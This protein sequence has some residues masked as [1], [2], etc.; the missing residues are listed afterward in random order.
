MSDRSQFIQ[1]VQ[2]ETLPELIGELWRL[3]ELDAYQRGMVRQLLEHCAARDWVKA[4]D[5]F[6]GYF[7]ANLLG[8][9]M[10]Q[11]DIA[12]KFDRILSLL[13]EKVASHSGGAAA[14]SSPAKKAKKSLRGTKACPDCGAR[15]GT[16]KKKCDKCDYQFPVKSKV[17]NNDEGSSGTTS[18]EPERVKKR[19]SGAAASS[20][21]AKKAKKSLK[22][23][24]ACPV[25]GARYGTRKKKCDK[26]G[27]QFPVKSKANKKD[28]GSSEAVAV[29]SSEPEETGPF[30]LNGF[31]PLYNTER[32]AAVAGDGTTHSHD[33][34]GVT[35]YM[36][37]GV[38]YYHG[39]HTSTAEEPNKEE[40]AVS[41]TLTRKTNGTPYEVPNLTEGTEQP[42][43]SGAAAL[44]IG[45]E[46]RVTTAPTVIS[47]NNAEA[48]EGEANEDGFDNPPGL[49]TS[50]VVEIR[51]KPIWRKKLFKEDGQDFVRGKEGDDKKAVQ[52]IHDILTKKKVKKYFV[53]FPANS[54]KKWQNQHI[55]AEWKQTHDTKPPKKLDESDELVVHWR[56]K[57]PPEIEPLPIFLPEDDGQFLVEDMSAAMISVYLEDADDSGN[58]KFKFKSDILLKYVEWRQLPDLPV[59]APY[60]KVRFQAALDCLHT[61]GAAGR[62]FHNDSKSIMLLSDYASTLDKVVHQAQKA[63]D[64]RIAARENRSGG[65]F[66]DPEMGRFE[67]GLARATGVANWDRDPPLVFDA[68]FVEQLPPTAEEVEQYLEDEHVQRQ[69]FIRQWAVT[70]AMQQMP[71]GSKRGEE[72]QLFE[73]KF[74]GDST[75]YAAK[76][77]R[78][79]PVNSVVE[80]AYVN[81][82]EDDQDWSNG[83]LDFALDTFRLVQ[84]MAPDDGVITE[85]SIEEEDAEQIAQDEEEDDA[86]SS[87][88]EGEEDELMGE[89]VQVQY[90]DAAGNLMIGTVTAK[91]L[92]EDVAAD[93]PLRVTDP[94]EYNVDGVW[95]GGDKLSKDEDVD[96]ETDDEVLCP[97]GVTR[98]IESTSG[99]LAFFADYE[100]H[101]GVTFEELDEAK[102]A[103]VDAEE[104][105]AVA[106][107][108]KELHEVDTQK[109]RKWRGR[110]VRVIEPLEPYVTHIKEEFYG[111]DVEEWQNEK[112]REHWRES[113][114][115]EP[116]TKSQKFNE[117]DPLVIE[118]RNKQPPEFEPL[119]QY[120]EGHVI[121]DIVTDDEGTIWKL[122]R[123]TDS[124]A[125]WEE[126]AAEHGAEAEATP[127]E[128]ETLSLNIPYTKYSQ[129]EWKEM[130]KKQEVSKDDDQIELVDLQ[131]VSSGEIFREQIA[132][133]LDQEHYA[134]D[135]GSDDEVDEDE[136]EEDEA[137]E[138]EADDVVSSDDAV[139]SEE[140][141]ESEP[142]D[143]LA[144]DDLG[145]SDAAEE[146]DEESAGEED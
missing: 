55:R 119:K 93:D 4:Y 8:F 89:D 11:F 63:L 128:E 20:P 25:C 121:G 69:L 44:V 87:E 23:T 47:E 29:S 31:Y 110:T 138:Q 10:L 30:D 52:K 129:K 13:G 68:S 22:G 123:F 112:I 80:Y 56:N 32:G 19:D 62:P 72:A 117:S 79:D 15:Y 81:P 100:G 65:E 99:D 96:Y 12:L 6:V 36:P 7:M 74:E 28:E 91:R 1:H 88:D 113:H 35:Y 46:A 131:D 120:E 90:M 5:V 70:C 114:D 105:A 64:E 41:P 108:E 48:K 84:A 9:Q 135:K 103:A 16:R 53:D 130:K 38:E 14:A 109:T 18:S 132:D 116:P 77:V 98:K 102:L 76:V 97:D 49:N 73:I 94:Y 95:V 66:K 86:E 134:A 54:V 136:M 33:I 146:T 40:S 60:D 140:E 139:S 43:Q 45:D 83:E 107:E 75:W 85:T 51:L 142:E 124:G 26:C 92:R 111:I 57:Q 42:D 122:V 3:E 137:A 104:S 27:Y 143:V 145:V 58:F 125:D 24:K 50:D 34:D 118:W 21:P 59:G 78:N 141:G 71:D 101:D 133:E 2:G 61:F 37:N 127:A 67:E 106:E 17:K 39:N 144:E 82:P 126:V 115:T